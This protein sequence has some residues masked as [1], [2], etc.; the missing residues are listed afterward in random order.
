VAQRHYTEEVKSAKEARVL[1]EAHARPRIYT[2]GPLGFTPYGETYHHDEV[3]ARLAGAHFE[4]RDPWDIPEDAQRVYDR[5]DTADVH[6]LEHANREVGLSNTDLIRQS[7]GMLAILD[8]TDVDSGTASEIG[9]AAARG[10]PVVGLRL[11]TRVTGDNRATIVN[12][13][14][15]SFIRQSGGEIVRTLDEAITALVRIFDKGPEQQVAS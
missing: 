8:G 7:D 13:Q 14:V 12:L 3:M 6:D 2:A 1:P 11:D 4:P 9:Y 5:R 15:E 10:I